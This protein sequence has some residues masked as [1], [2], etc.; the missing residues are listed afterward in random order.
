MVLDFPGPVRVI[1]WC[2]Y[3]EAKKLFFFFPSSI[4]LQIICFLLISL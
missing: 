2:S 1:Y 3:L 4:C